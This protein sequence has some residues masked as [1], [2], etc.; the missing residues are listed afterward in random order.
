MPE[1]LSYHFAKQAKEIF[2]RAEI[3]GREATPEERGQVEE[4]LARAEKARRAE[5]ANGEV[6]EFQKGFGSAGPVTADGFSAGP[7]GTRFVNSAAYKTIAD[8]GNRG[9][10]WS[11]GPVEVGMLAK[12]TLL[13]TPGTALTPPEYRA[14]VVETLFQR[15][16]V[17]DLL[18]QSQVTGSQVRY[19]EETTAT[20]AADTVSEGEAKPESALDFTERVTPI[21]KIATTLPVSDELLEDASAIET[22][23]NARLSLFVK[24]QEEAQILRGD[25]TAPDLRGIIGASGVNIA[26]ASATGGTATASSL[27]TVM[28][29]TRGSSQLDPDALIVHPNQWDIMRT[30]RDSQGQYFGGGPFVGSYGGPQGPAASS[31]FSTASYWGVRVVVSTAVGAGT[32]LL[33]NFTEGA[34]LFRRSGVTVDV[35]NSHEDYFRRN[36]NL[37]RAEERVGLGIYRPSAFTEIRFS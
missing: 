36:L 4:L 12:G 14:G 2:T 25:G 18:K 19:V 33:G 28:N 15:L 24:V 27:F 1:S 21:R 34:E 32:A 17:A 6:A 5:K 29:N 16:Y 20:N 35:S 31:Q 9:A 30:G 22:Y 7:P 23:L 8:A 26:G 13:S 10:A 3:E 11:T 37:L